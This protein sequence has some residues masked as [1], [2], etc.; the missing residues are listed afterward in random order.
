[1]AVNASITDLDLSSTVPWNED[2]EYYEDGAHDPQPQGLN[3]DPTAA[4]QS[5][6]RVITNKNRALVRFHVPYSFGSVMELWTDAWSQ[7]LR[8]RSLIL[9]GIRRRFGCPSSNGT[10]PIN[11]AMGQIIA[12]SQ[13]VF[14]RLPDRPLTPP[15]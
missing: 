5:L 8:K 12:T 15:V 9:N 6:F 4:I 7:G 3:D 11:A 10:V 1:M 14:V 2:K 13:A